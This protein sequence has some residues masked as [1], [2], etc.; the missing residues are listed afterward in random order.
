MSKAKR[1]AVALRGVLLL[2]VACVLGIANSAWA[3][4]KDGVIFKITAGSPAANPNPAATNEVI[5][6]K[7]K[8]ELFKWESGHE[9]VPPNITKQEYTLT[10]GADSEITSVAPDFTVAGDKHSAA[11]TINGGNP[12]V[13]FDVQAVLKYTQPGAKQVILD[14]K[15][16]FADGSTLTPIGGPC[17]I[18][19]TV[20]DLVVRF[21]EPELRPGVNVARADTTAVTAVRSVADANAV[22]ITLSLDN[23]RATLTAPAGPPLGTF[24]IP[25]N[26]AQGNTNATVQ[27]VNLSNNDQ[28]TK[29]QSKDAAG[30]VLAFIPVTVVEPK[31]VISSAAGAGIVVNPVAIPG[32]PQAVRWSW[33]VNLTVRDA[34]HKPLRSQWAGTTLEENVV[35]NPP[36][37]GQG[38]WAGLGGINAFATVVDPVGATLTLVPGLTVANFLNGI[39]NMVGSV[40]CDVNITHR[41]NAPEQ[42]YG[43]IITNI[44]RVETVG[45]N[46]N[47]GIVRDQ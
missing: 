24:T 26:Q 40:L 10:A 32:Q 42:I 2:V 37:Q 36:F 35:W 33:N 4:D 23:A 31:E 41:L 43:N 15:V 11:K 1:R 13:S 28:D 34:F 18:D 45:N 22:T 46:K 25:A 27:G 38:G 3:A 21:A 29:L 16:T 8:V 9:V 12:T 6:I 39:P 14:G 30:N 17:Q 19:I 7:F 5:T 20:A 44:H 47:N